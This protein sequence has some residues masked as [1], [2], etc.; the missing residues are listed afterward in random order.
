MITFTRSHLEII[1]FGNQISLALFEKY[2]KFEDAKG[3]KLTDESDESEIET[4]LDDSSIEQHENFDCMVIIEEASLNFSKY[5]SVVLDNL[6]NSD[7]NE[8]ECVH[9][10]ELKSKIES[11]CHHND[12]LVRDNYRQ[13]VKTKEKA[14]EKIKALS[15]RNHDLK[16]E[17]AV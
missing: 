16:A 1:H 9:C 7:V 5:Y 14:N 6:I 4:D 12:Q 10:D 13:I 2:E 15:D 8:P 3:D 11:S 17:V